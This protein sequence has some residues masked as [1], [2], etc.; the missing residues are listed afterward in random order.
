M[1]PD[2]MYLGPESLDLKIASRVGMGSWSWGDRLVWGY[3]SYDTDLSE[4]TM[5][6]AFTASLS[7][8]VNLVDTAEAYGAG[9]LGGWGT[10]ERI[11][12]R[13]LAAVER[14]EAVIVTKYQPLPWRFREAASL[15]AALDASCARLG[16]HA[17][18][19]LLI[20]SPLGSLRSIKT[21][22][23]ALAAGVDSGKTKAVGVSNYSAAELRETHRVLAERG[24]PLAVNQVEYSLCHTLPEHSG[25][26]D[27]CSELGVSVMAYSP[28]AMGRLTGKYSREHQPKGG[29]RFGAQP[30]DKIQPILDELARIGAAHGGKTQAQVALNWVVRKGAIPVPGAKNAAQA[31]ANAGAMGWEITAE[32]VQALDEV[33]I[34]GSL[35]FGQHG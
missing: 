10:S 13:C 28:M 23:G 25:L 11:L 18:D 8:G 24:I 5:R 35:K 17:V 21:L 20:H 33:A 26:F 7:H 32:E 27:T 6:A 30:F 29:R 4:D 31:A 9:L 34:Q 22:A 19:V 3:N 1:D 15:V 16:T 2:S 14:T 12:G